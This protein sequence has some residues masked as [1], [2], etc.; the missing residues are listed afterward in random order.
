M[1]I[2]KE[3]LEMKIARWMCGVV[4]RMDKIT[5]ECTSLV[6]GIRAI[7][8]GGGGYSWRWFGF[9]VRIDEETNEM[10]DKKWCYPIRIGG[11]GRTE[12]EHR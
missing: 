10:I 8:N 5:N 4:T 6:S 9:I 1:R 3:C 7:L 11:K 12:T 2:G